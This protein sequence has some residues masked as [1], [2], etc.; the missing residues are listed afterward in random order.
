MSQTTETSTPEPGSFA[1]LFEAQAMA[2]A[3]PYDLLDLR[4]SPGTHDHPVPDG[5]ELPR[6]A[7]DLKGSL[8]Q[9][10]AP[11]VGR[12]NLSLELAAEIAEVSPRTLRRRLREEGGTF[13]QVLDRVLFEAA[14]QKMTEPGVS[15]TD[16]SAALGYANSANFARAFH[17]WTGESP[18]MYRSRRSIAG[19]TNKPHFRLEVR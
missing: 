8:Q 15:L 18:S 4:L 13:Q 11:L 19:R 7:T 9:A 14:E 6:A 2:I 10:L 12:A 17:R 1:A 5:P 3:V 16:V